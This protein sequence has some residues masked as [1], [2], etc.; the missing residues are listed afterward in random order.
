MIRRFLR[1]LRRSERPAD[2]AAQPPRAPDERFVDAWGLRELG[3]VLCVDLRPVSMLRYG[4]VEGAW[5]L[6]SLTE[7]SLPTDRTVV[8]LSPSPE[9][10]AE[11][12]T[13][14]VSWGGLAAWRAA[15]KVLLAVQ[16]ST[17]ALGTDRSSSMLV[18]L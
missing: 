11:T 4:F 13:L 18:M 2:A 8:V 9:A 12:T 1:T 5:L 16:W 6:P 15:R 3:S 10:V 17:W 7:V 14:R